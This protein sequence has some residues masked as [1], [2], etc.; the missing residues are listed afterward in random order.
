MM[1]KYTES[2]CSCTKCQSMCKTPCIGTPDE[3]M[4]IAQAG[5]GDRLAMSTWAAGMILGTHEKPVDLI[6]PLYDKRKGAC[7]FFKD[8]LCELHDLGLKPKEGRYASCKEDPIKSRDELLATPLYECIAE[9][10]KFKF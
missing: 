1:K 5:F 2:V 7:S 9:W 8:G 6:A 3:I 4:K 10:E